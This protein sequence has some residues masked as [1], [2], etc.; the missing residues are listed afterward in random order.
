MCKLFLRQPINTYK[1][2]THCA[3]QIAIDYI[4]IVMGI[5]GCKNQCYVYYV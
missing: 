3:Q 1:L 2:H 4:M 5:E